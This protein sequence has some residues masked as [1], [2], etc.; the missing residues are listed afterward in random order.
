MKKE[1]ERTV[2][3]AKIELILEMSLNATKEEIS[4]I[5]NYINSRLLEGTSK[6]KVKKARKICA[7]KGKYLDS[8]VS[9]M[10][11][12]PETPYTVEQMSQ[13]T[14]VSVPTIRTYIKQLRT[15]RKVK[16]VGWDMTK[17]GPATLLY[18]TFR[19]PLKA[20]KTVTPEEGY[21]SVNNFVKKHKDLVGT[22]MPSAFLYAVEQENLTVYPLLLGIGVVKGYKLTELKRLAKKLY[23]TPST[24]KPNKRK[25]NKKAKKAKRK[26][27]KKVVA[28][29]T[30]TPENSLGILERL[31]KRSHNKSD[32]IKF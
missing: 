4:C 20:L 1:I 5:M 10:A 12:N 27:T 17:T 8:I 23:S 16:L 7:R 13:E 19:S 30:V 21:D 24:T 22:S 6:V 15:S 32:L 26:Y 18:Q 25:Y 31:F 11:E 2:A 14:G 28:E 3:L 9:I 29:P